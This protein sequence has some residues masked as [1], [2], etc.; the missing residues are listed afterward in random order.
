MLKVPGLPLKC[1]SLAGSDAG[2]QRR[3]LEPTS[4]LSRA[5]SPAGTAGLALRCCPGPGTRWEQHDGVELR[6][7][8]TDGSVVVSTPTHCH[9]PSD[10][11]SH[12]PRKEWGSD[13][14]AEP[15]PRGSTPG[16]VWGG[17]YRLQP[18]VASAVLSHCPSLSLSVASHKMHQGTQCRG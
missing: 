7:E 5:R 9:R 8:L 16:G 10:G 4:L 2:A 17:V 13:R 11:Q 3:P 6:E 1:Q 15:T 14:G 18:L 12:C